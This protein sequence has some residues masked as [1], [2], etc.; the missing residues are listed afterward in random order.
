[1]SVIYY[2]V[3][4]VSLAGLPTAYNYLTDSL[5]KSPLSLIISGLPVIVVG[6]YL[7]FRL[8]YIEHIFIS[9]TVYCKYSVLHNSK[10]YKHTNNSKHAVFSGYR[11]I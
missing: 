1:M 11:I 9:D 8:Y 4:Y 2:I 5:L 3:C 6:I 7:F 10:T